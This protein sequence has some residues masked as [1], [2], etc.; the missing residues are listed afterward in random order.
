MAAMGEK[1]MFAIRP[2]ERPCVD[3]PSDARGFTRGLAARAQVL[4]CVRPVDAALI[5]VAGLYGDRGSGPHRFCALEALG[6][7]PGFPNPVF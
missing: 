3:A 2:N 6:R 5:T 7:F 4:P 1:Q